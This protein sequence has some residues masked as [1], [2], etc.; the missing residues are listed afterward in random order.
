VKRITTENYR[1]DPYYP[2]VTRATDAILA[3]TDVVAPVEVFI[4]M[5]LLRRE[6]LERWRF[7]RV[8]YLEQVIRCNLAKASRILRILRM[9]AHDLHLRPSQ[10][11]Y[12]RLGKGTRIPLRFSKTGEPALEKAYSLHFIRATS[13]HRSPIELE[14]DIKPVPSA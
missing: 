14:N 2:R 6:D 9:H 3:K 11:A 10:T 1:T 5:D 13:K 7:G 12:V 8:T 4:H